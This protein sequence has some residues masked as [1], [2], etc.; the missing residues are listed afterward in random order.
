MKNLCICAVIA[1]AG[2]GGNQQLTVNNL[3]LTV[4]DQLYVS[5]PMGYFCDMVSTG[6][7]K[8]KLL[9][10]SPA[11]P[12]DQQPGTTPRDPGVEHTELDIIVGGFFPGG[13]HE[14]LSNPFTLSKVNCVTGPG[15]LGTAYFYHYP[16]NATNPDTTI[17]VDTGSVK[18]DQFDFMN[19]MPVKGS[20]DLTF[21]TSQVTGTI[22]ALDCDVPM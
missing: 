21:G 10:Y 12:L 17:Q 4:A 14:N 15:D 20:F 7:I 5:Q 1:L 19:V 11:C 8:I 9:D 13:Q 3:P 18:L 16:A 2:C 6:Q 22:D